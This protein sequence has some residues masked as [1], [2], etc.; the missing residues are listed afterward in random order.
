MLNSV[1]KQKYLKYKFKYLN[2]KKQIGGAAAAEPNAEP[3][4]KKCSACTY[5]N[6]GHN[7]KCVKCSTPLPI[8]KMKDT[9]LEPLAFDNHIDNMFTGH[10]K[11]DTQNRIVSTVDG[12]HGLFFGLI[13]EII[14]DD[15]NKT[16][17]C[18]YCPLIFK[19]LD[20]KYHTNYYKTFGF[21]GCNGMILKDKYLK[22]EKSASAEKKIPDI[23]NINKKIEEIASQVILLPEF[24]KIINILNGNFEPY[25]PFQ[26]L[27]MTSKSD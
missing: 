3:N 13:K 24:P 11:A 7:E 15:N 2:L 12:A 14:E 1:T 16:H 18:L 27:L 8:L 20:L 23:E 10:I 17:S 6:S 4:T 26:S 19:M 9:D 22:V 21:S 25:D 5:E